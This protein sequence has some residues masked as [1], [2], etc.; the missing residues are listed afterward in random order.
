MQIHEIKRKTKN[1]KGKYIGR[2]GRRGKT[3]GKGTKGQNSRAGRKK[4]PELR[5]II[6]K[7]PKLRGYRFASIVN[8]AMPVNLTT[9]EKNFGGGDEVN[10][11]V[12]F[13]KGLIKKVNGTLPKVKILGT[14]EISKKVSISGCLVSASAR[15]MIVKAG[16]TVSS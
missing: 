2:G 5:D 10:P 15:D 12:L 16:G 6:K 3:S 13:E 14:G 7:I 9:I 1:R 4:R 8:K 11:K